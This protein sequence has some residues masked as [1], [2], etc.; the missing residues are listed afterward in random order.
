MLDIKLFLLST[1]SMEWGRNNK[2]LKI[3]ME[4]TKREEMKQKQENYT[5]LLGVED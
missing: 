3:E 4:N 2:F 1:N 5:Y